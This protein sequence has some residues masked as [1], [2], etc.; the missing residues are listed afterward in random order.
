MHQ[1]PPGRYVFGKRPNDSQAHCLCGRLETESRDLSEVPEV[2]I[3]ES[4]A[5]P[6]VETVCI[7]GICEN[8]QD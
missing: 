8:L 2:I 7:L 3:Y 4:D 1:V 6:E 5:M